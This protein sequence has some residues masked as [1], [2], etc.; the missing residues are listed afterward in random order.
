MGGGATVAQ[1]GLALVFP[2]ALTLGLA[3][4]TLWLYGRK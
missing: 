3:P 2:A 1:V 4:V